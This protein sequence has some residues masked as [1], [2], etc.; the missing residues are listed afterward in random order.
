MVEEVGHGV[1]LV[2]EEVRFGLPPVYLVGIAQATDGVVAF[3]F[4]QHIEPFCRHLG[5]IVFP[6]ADDGG[7]FRFGAHAQPA[8]LVAELRHT[9][10][11][12]FQQGERAALTVS[13]EIGA[14]VETQTVEAVDAPR[15]VKVHQHTA[16]VKE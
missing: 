3:D 8:Q 9:D 11:A 13:A 15:L 10:V 1:P 5:E 4:E 12:A 2:I 16:E 7:I 6:G 14:Y